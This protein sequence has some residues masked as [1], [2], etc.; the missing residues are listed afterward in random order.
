MA[1]LTGHYRQFSDWPGRARCALLK[2]PL[3]KGHN[4]QF[5]DWPPALNESAF[6][7]AFIRGSYRH[8]LKWP[9]PRP[10]FHVDSHF[11]S[12]SLRPTEFSLGT[13]RER[14]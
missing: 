14:T 11:D 7:L 8:F 10:F 5:F 1:A 3:E 13:C 9:V 6:K 2:R 4:R 12:A